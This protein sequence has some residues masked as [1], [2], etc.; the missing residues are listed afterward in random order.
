MTARRRGW[1]LLTWLDGGYTVIRVGEDGSASTVLR[2]AVDDA[3]TAL[4]VVG[5]T[6]VARVPGHWKPAG[7]V[8]ADRL[9][10]TPATYDE[11]DKGAAPL[12]SVSR[13]QVV[14]HLPERLR[15]RAA[16]AGLVAGDDSTTA[17][18]VD[19]EARGV[20]VALDAPDTDLWASCRL[21]AYALTPGGGTAMM[22]PTYVNGLGAGGLGLL[23]G[24][25]RAGR[26][27]AR[28]Q[29]E[30]RRRGRRARVDA[31]DV[32]R[33]GG[34]VGDDAAAPLTVTPCFGC[35]P[36]LDTHM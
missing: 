30:P 34:A 3:D 25:P 7:F 22:L 28:L 6:A 1:L 20:I 18:P 27:L 36:S 16:A 29:Q 33:G 2:G 32:D 13:Q 12:W 14:G 11:A 21:T 9:V 31:D 23:R 15:P 26:G 10:L 35:G 8:D 5:T 19:G 4:R 17:G 24:Q